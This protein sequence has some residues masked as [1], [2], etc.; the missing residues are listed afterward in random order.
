LTLRAAPSF[1]TSP[2]AGDWTRCPD[3]Q[4]SLGRPLTDG[5]RFLFGLAGAAGDG[6][7]TRRRRSAPDDQ[8]GSRPVR[9][10]SYGRGCGEEVQRGQE[11]AG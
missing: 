5:F 7:R 8:S 4:P 6:P 1:S 9:A 11:G 10:R 3:R 2:G